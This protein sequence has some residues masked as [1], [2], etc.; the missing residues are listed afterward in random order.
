[1]V[2][3]RSVGSLPVTHRI[4]TIDLISRPSQG[5][6]SRTCPMHI[7]SSLWL[8]R[9]AGN[10]CD[11]LNVSAR[12]NRLD[13]ATDLIKSFLKK[14]CELDPRPTRFCRL[15]VPLNRF[16]YRLKFLSNSVAQNAF[17]ADKRRISYTI[18]WV[19][20]VYASH[21]NICFSVTWKY[22]TNTLLMNMWR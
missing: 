16:L 8:D 3:P 22:V 18:C 21:E 2:V 4:N 12:R 14:R 13:N 20:N 17:V 15:K 5:A 7:P 1:M 6:L 19:W 10:V 11:I 9:F